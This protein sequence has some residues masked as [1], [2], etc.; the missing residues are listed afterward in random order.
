MWLDTFPLWLGDNTCIRVWKFFFG[1]KKIMIVHKDLLHEQNKVPL[2]VK[3]L[4]FFHFCFMICKISAYLKSHWIGHIRRKGVCLN[5]AAKSR[6]MGIIHDEVAIYIH[7]YIYIYIYIYIGACVCVC[8][9]VVHS[10]SFQTFLYGHLELSW[11]LENSVCYCY[12]SYEM[13]DQFLWFQI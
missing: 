7:I 9:Y 8:V 5:S 12:T 10:I 13:T 4:L 2:T 3:T 11:T 1:L 6:K